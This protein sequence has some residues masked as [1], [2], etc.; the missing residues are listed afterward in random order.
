M[1]K[2]HNKGLLLAV[3]IIGIVTM[4]V[5]FATLSQ[6]LDITSTAVVKNKAQNWNVQFT[7]ASCSSTNGYST[8]TTQ[9]T[10]ASTTISGLVGSFK[11]PGDEITCTIQVSNSGTI[12]AEVTGF[13]T[14]D[15][16]Q[17][18]TYTGSGTSKTQDET[19]VNGKIIYTLK[20]ND[21]TSVTVGDDLNH[22]NNATLKLVLRLDDTLTDLPVNAVTISNFKSYIIY[23]QK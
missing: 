17:S 14:Q 7:S 4:T 3:L 8:V 6:R 5:A 9:P 11:A 18:I 15:A 2:D 13:A 20:Y 1:N 22:S 16:T 21:N 10:V 19:L 23:G 12:D